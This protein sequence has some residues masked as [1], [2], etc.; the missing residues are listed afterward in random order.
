MEN[1]TTLT[2]LA[3]KLG[4]E[5]GPQITQ[6]IAL[7]YRIEAFKMLAGGFFCLILLAVMYFMLRKLFFETKAAKDAL[8]AAPAPTIHS[9]ED[10]VKDYEKLAE[11]A[12]PSEASVWILLLSIPIALIA[13]ILLLNP[14]TWMAALGYPDPMIAKSALQAVNMM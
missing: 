4:H 13:L 9:T 7:T 5:F 11:E 12:K 1:Q 10:D 6:A 3:D 2:Q 8:A 14:Y